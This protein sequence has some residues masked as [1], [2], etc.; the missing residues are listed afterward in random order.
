MNV[1]RMLRLS[2]LGLGIS[3]AAFSA[4]CAA[5]NGHGKDA[6][7]GAPVKDR[8]QFVLTAPPAESESQ[9]RTWTSTIDALTADELS[10]LMSM[11]K[12]VAEGGDEAARRA[13]HAAALQAG[14]PNADRLRAALDEAAERYFKATPPGDT[15]GFVLA[16][17][18]LAHAKWAARPES[19]ASNAV[20]KWESR[21]AVSTRLNDLVRA[22]E[23]KQA[24]SADD[25]KW[26]LGALAG[27]D[28]E[29]REAVVQCWSAK[30][31][32]DRLALTG[33]QKSLTDLLQSADARTREAVLRILTLRGAPVHADA[34]VPYLK[35]GDAGVRAAAVSAIAKLTPGG[36]LQVLTK[37]AEAI[38]D[39][40][41]A[42]MRR[43]LAR[44]A[45]DAPNAK[46]AEA[47]RS[48]P[49]RVQALLIGVL[50]D[51][52]A[53]DQLDEVL[54]LA[55]SAT[56]ASVR[57]AAAD[58]IGVLGAEA[59]IPDV[60]ALLLKAQSDAERTAA[61][62]AL[63]ALVKRP[64]TSPQAA[65]AIVSAIKPEDD[66]Q[67]A[68]LL[69]VLGKIG[70]EQAWG[71]VR[72]AI[73]DPR[74][75]VKDAAFRALSDWPETTRAQQI[76]E[77]ARSAADLTHHVLAIRAAIRLSAMDEQSAV[78]QRVINLSAIAKAARRA[79]EKRLVVAKLGEIGDSA[80]VAV[81]LVSASDPELALDAQAALLAVADKLAA[82][83]PEIARMAVQSVMMKG[84]TVELQRR[85]EEVLKHV[86]EF[87]DFVVDWMAAGPYTLPNVPGRELLDRE[88]G[89]ELSQ[90]GV[91]WKP[92][93]RNAD[94]KR[95]WNIDLTS[96]FAG[97]DRAVYLWSQVYSGK[98]Q[99]ARFEIGSDDGIKVWL[100]GAVVHTNNASRGCE[101]GS[102]IV[103]VKLKAGW[104][105]ITLKVTNINGGFGAC[106]RVR[107]AQGEHLE[108]M[109][110]TLDPQ[111][112]R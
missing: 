66:G 38:D 62:D 50:R 5:Q 103:A 68:A 34:L 37:F 24:P 41:L 84:P 22:T 43:E 9:R 101:R 16:Q 80:S 71:A 72:K 91:E 102:D 112:M 60:L 61:V 70:G 67:Y 51:R 6:D 83:K 108:G 97:A 15:T 35:D 32:M 105:P 98:S 110:V 73:D 42:A 47:S 65:A 30:P 56:D 57:A 63:A 36:G 21:S 111:S 99:D 44:N 75:A 88:M 55:R 96:Q 76:L 58:A 25:S 92:V 29:A 26:L 52:F 93:A 89:P 13:L 4:G 19:G 8:V 2:V 54:K 12:P 64:G 28:V 17:G 94:P 109:R 74:L 106:L 45:S 81:L 1:R 46:I 49:P 85:G 95:L 48:A 10:R 23:A 107:G 53:T 27:S 69:G 59:N 20:T 90:K 39:A 14:G 78:S 100:N 77:L 40:G 104:N 7:A 86:T 31:E 33:S 82:S 79:D 11:L 87:E 18:L 3:F